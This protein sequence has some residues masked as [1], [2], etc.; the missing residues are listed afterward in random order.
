VFLDI[1]MP[2]LSGPEVLQKNPPRQTTKV[3]LMSAYSGED[4]KK[5]TQLADLFIAKPFEDIFHVVERA[6]NLLK[7]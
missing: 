7:S 4:T 3:I 6:Q 5:Y 2:G 1:L